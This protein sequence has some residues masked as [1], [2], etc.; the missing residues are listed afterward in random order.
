MS[1]NGHCCHLRR[2][3]FEFMKIAARKTTA[4]SKAGCAKLVLDNKEDPLHLRPPP[5]RTAPLVGS[6]GAIGPRGVGAVAAA[7]AAREGR[8]A[9]WSSTSQARRGEA[10]VR[11]TMAG[12]PS[13]GLAFA[14]DIRALARWT[15]RTTFIFRT[16]ARAT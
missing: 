16:V 8:G 5:G 2:I 14:N 13:L 4:A 10:T 11:F 9:V 15:V 12:D 3:R 7:A 6:E 1:G